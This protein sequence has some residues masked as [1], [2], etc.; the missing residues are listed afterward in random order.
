MAPF[1]SRKITPDGVRTG[2]WSQ[3]TTRLGRA[4]LRRR[5]WHMAPGLAPLALWIVPRACYAWEASLLP[6][7]LM[8][9]FQSIL[10]DE[11]PAE[12]MRL[13]TIAWFV[14]A[15]AV[16]AVRHYP[17]FAR[18]RDQGRF[19]SPLG[20]AGPLLLMLL[21]VP[22]HP[23]FTLTV[24][25]VLAFG[26]GSAT[27]GGILLGRRTLPWNPQKTWIG[28]L[29]FLLCAAPLSSLYYAIEVAV[30]RSDSSSESRML[31]IACGV[32][33]TLVAA[34]VESLPLPDRR[35]DNFFVGL[36]AGATVAIVH[37][38]LAG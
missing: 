2:H 34:V 21:L 35:N 25:A 1:L 13:M 30:G 11:E 14:M 29:C 15:M 23:E 33:A 20:Y 32:G 28:T 17:G 37:G 4:E 9:T 8:G 16:M 6:T 22:G 31:A 18:E 5:I 12:I 38:L 24:L 19:E 10:P 3:C 27:L 7:S 26:D 36:S